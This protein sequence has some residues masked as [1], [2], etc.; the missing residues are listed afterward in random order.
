MRRGTPSTYRQSPACSGKTGARADLFGSTEPMEPAVA[1]VVPAEMPRAVRWQ[2]VNEV[3]CLAIAPE[4]LSSV[5][6]FMRR[7][8]LQQRVTSDSFIAQ[9]MF[10]LA[11]D[12]DSGCRNGPLYGETLTTALIVHLA[13]AQ[14]G[15]SLESIH[16]GLSRIDLQRVLDYVEAN[17]ERVMTLSELADLVSMNKFRFLRAFNQ[18]LHMP[19]YRYCLLRRLE[20]AKQL[21]H[22]TEYSLSDIALRTGFSS[23]SHFGTA[24]RSYTGV[25]PRIFREGTR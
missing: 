1:F 25:S 3:L 13:C 6:H 11:R 5:T 20:R 2:S 19:P 10:A 8:E 23:Q 9:T 16:P 14:G 22:D 17:L 24:F 7:I 4:H 21:L 18:A 12:L 15:E